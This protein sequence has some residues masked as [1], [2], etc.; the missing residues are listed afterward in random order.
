MLLTKKW[1]IGRIEAITIK[2][3]DEG[4]VLTARL[5]GE[6]WSTSKHKTGQEIKAVTFQKTNIKKS[7]NFYSTHLVFEI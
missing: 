4:W 6:P 7:G 2:Q 3:E 5:K 1:I